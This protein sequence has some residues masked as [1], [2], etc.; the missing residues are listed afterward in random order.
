MMKKTKNNPEQ[1][2]QREEK[3]SAGRAMFDFAAETGFWVGAGALAGAANYFYEY[4]MRPVLHD[5]S[6][7]HEPQHLPYTRG[8]R[9]MNE[10]P[11][12]EDWFEKSDDG[13]RIHANFIPSPLPEG[14]HRYAICVHGYS[15]TSESVGQYARVYRDVYGM[16]VL[17]PDLRGHGKSEGTYVGY[18]YHA[19]LDIIVWIDRILERDPKAMILLHGISM[20]A[21]TVMMTT[22]EHLPSNVKACVEDAGY[23]TA[24]EEFKHVYNNLESKPP[25][26][27]EIMMPALRTVALIRSGYAL[28]QASPLEAVKR[29]KTPTLFIH[30]ENDTF[31]PCSMM[32]KLFE[33]AACEKM[34]LIVKGAEHVRSVVVDPE[35]YWEKV[36]S[37]LSTVA[38]ELAE[39]KG[40]GTILA[41]ALDFEPVGEPEPAE[42]PEP[43]PADE[44]VPAEQDGDIL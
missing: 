28:G 20:G 13:L 35:G 32:K 39:K 4:S 29:S 37:F 43:E 9:W 12:R 21:A 33:A 44:P 22:G 25:V 19:R 8:R 3:K 42:V 2:E 6:H 36:D 14:D 34:Y 41:D 17:L 30:G 26:P 23:S 10:H 18:G 5:S 7:D 31:I 1:E 38:P 11:L 27:V 40:D 15:D 16:N 24:V